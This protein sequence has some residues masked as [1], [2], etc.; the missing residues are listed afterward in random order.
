MK[1]VLS[2]AGA[3]KEP[4]KPAKER[5]ES[6]DNRTDA[7][8]DDTAAADAKA[9]SSSSSAAT[10]KN[11]WGVLGTCCCLVVFNSLRFVTW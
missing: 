8:D 5:N 1:Q 9:K 11:A 7:G 6:E 10:L 4:K 2:N 3:A